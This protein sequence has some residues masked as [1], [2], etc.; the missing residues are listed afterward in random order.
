MHTFST[1]YK[2]M[3]R[4]LLFPYGYKLHKSLFYKEINQ[5]QCFFIT[6][7]KERYAPY[8]TVYLDMLPYCMD[9]EKEIEDVCDISDELGFDLPGLMKKLEP[10]LFHPE[11]EIIKEYYASRLYADFYDEDR[12]INSLRNACSDMEKYI[13]P[14]F[15]RF[16]DLEYF[17]AE[18]SETWNFSDPVHYGLSLKL[19]HYEDALCCIEYRISDCRRIMADHVQTQNRLHTGTLMDRDKVILKKDPDYAEE[20]TKWIADCAEKIATYEKIQNHILHRSTTELDKMVTEIEERSRIH[21]KRLLN[22]NF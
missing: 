12:T 14:Y 10:S 9:I 3:F 19:H 7:K 4:Q 18:E 22:A 1:L 5:E 8:Y 13:L 20:L 15:H 16:A 11:P 6:A 21:L 2:K 17:Y